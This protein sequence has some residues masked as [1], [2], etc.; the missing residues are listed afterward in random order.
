M[1]LVNAYVAF[2][3]IFDNPRSP[4]K[5][6]CGKVLETIKNRIA[7]I[8]TGVTNLNISVSFMKEVFICA[9]FVRIFDSKHYQLLSIFLM[10]EIRHKSTKHTHKSGYAKVKRNLQR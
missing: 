1:I 2:G 8:V 7:P 3:R 4:K 5:V 6:I 9:I 10:L